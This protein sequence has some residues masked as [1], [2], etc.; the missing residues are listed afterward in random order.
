[1][2]ARRKTLRVSPSTIPELREKIS[3]RADLQKDAH[4]IEAALEADKIIVSLD[5]KA[6]IGFEGLNLRVRDMHNIR[7]INPVSQRIGDIVK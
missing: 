6:K 4:L 7:W 1:M 2:A 5:D 3:D